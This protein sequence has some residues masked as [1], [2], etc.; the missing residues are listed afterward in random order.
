VQ[1]QMPHGV[2]LVL[3]GLK[4]SCA[5]KWRKLHNR[6]Q[7]VGQRARS[8][9]CRDQVSQQ[10]VRVC[11]GKSPLESQMYMLQLLYAK[12]LCQQAQCAARPL[13]ISRFVL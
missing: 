2:S 8:L 5:C 12:L 7:H 10:Q 1:Q 13:V 3:P 9:V 6:M 11:G 4:A